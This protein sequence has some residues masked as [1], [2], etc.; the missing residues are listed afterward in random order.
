MII[1]VLVFRHFRNPA[2]VMRKINMISIVANRH[3][4]YQ[5]SV[6]L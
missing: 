1:A 6:Q 5:V 3:S 2:F 4:I